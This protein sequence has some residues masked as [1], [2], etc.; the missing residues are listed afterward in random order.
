ISCLDDMLEFIM[1]GASAVSVGTM[2]MV[3]PALSLALVGEFEEYMK[4]E[5]IKNMCDIIGIARRSPDGPS[6]D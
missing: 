2:N 6:G 3:D 5:K 4:R 1:A